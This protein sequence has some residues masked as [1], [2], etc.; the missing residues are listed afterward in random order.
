MNIV[1]YILDH[2]IND[3]SVLVKPSFSFN[4]RYIDFDFFCIWI[5]HYHVE[6]CAILLTTLLWML[7]PWQSCHASVIVQNFASTFLSSH[8][9]WSSPAQ[10]VN[11]GFWTAGLKCLHFDT[12][13]PSCTAACSCCHC[14]CWHCWTMDCC[15]SPIMSDN[16]S[17][18]HNNTLH[19][20]SNDGVIIDDRE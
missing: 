6:M 13:N 2:I 18:T 16:E 19:Q 1:F 9:P 17:G 3:C 4:Q 12:M 7:L 5:V 10:Q 14:M 20:S 15:F 11:K 8:G